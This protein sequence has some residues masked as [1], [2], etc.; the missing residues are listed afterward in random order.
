M[1]F[2][3]N[4]DGNL[5]CIY[6][7]PLIWDNS[8]VHLV[9][10]VTGFLTT[11]NF[12]Y[13]TKCVTCVFK[14]ILYIPIVW[15]QWLLTTEVVYSYHNGWED[16]DT[17]QSLLSDKH[18]LWI[19]KGQLLKR[20]YPFGHRDM[21]DNLYAILWPVL[22]GFSIPISPVENPFWALLFV[23]DTMFLFHDPLWHHIR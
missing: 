22:I 5:L 19:M 6:S 10:L 3:I 15:K 16:P 2:T 8:I 9:D 14:L 23:V 7:L 1:I 4:M 17:S 18:L 11:L 21:Q 13:T 20:L 12:K